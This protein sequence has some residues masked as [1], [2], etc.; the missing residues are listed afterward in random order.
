MKKLFITLLV[1]IPCVVSQAQ[2]SQTSVPDDSVFIRIE[3]DP[4]LSDPMHLAGAFSRCF[5]PCDLNKDGIVTYS[6]AAQTTMLNLSPGGRKNIISNYDFLKHFPNLT[7]LHL[8][9]ATSEEIDLSHNPKLEEV[10]C[11]LA[12]WLKRVKLSKGCCPRIYYP[13]MEG[14]FTVT[15]VP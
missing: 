7:H 3:Q 12:L 13:D 1:L 8:G 9:N 10:V 15:I 6:E 2:S 4:M 14:D 5:T 11:N